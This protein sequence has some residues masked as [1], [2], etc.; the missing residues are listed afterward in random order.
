MTTRRQKQKSKLMPTT[1]TRSAHKRQTKHKEIL[2]AKGWTYRE[3][4]KELGVHLT[5]FNRV[6]QGERISR[7]ILEAI[8]ALPENTLYK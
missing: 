6:L 3:A 4:S 1:K 2:A 7:R 5:H 8:E